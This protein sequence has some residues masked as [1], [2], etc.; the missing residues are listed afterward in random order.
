MLKVSIILPC[1]NVE[2]YI[3]VCLDSLRAQTLGDIE[4]ICVDDLST[5]NTVSIIRHYM[6]QDDRIHLIQHRENRGVG[7]ARNSGRG[8]ATGQYVSFIDPDDYVDTDFFEKLYSC[9]HKNN[10][11]VA[12]AGVKR[13]DATN[14]KVVIGELNEKIKID[15]MYLSGEHWSA[16][17]KREFLD[18]NNIYYP[19]DVPTGQDVVFLSHIALMQPRI[20]VVDDTYYHYI[21]NRP[22]SLDSR[23]LSHDKVLSRI[24]MLEY[25]VELLNRHEIQDSQARK[26]YLERHLLDHFMYTFNKNMDELDKRLMFDWLFTRKDFLTR[27]LLATKYTEYELDGLFSGNF[28]KFILPE[29]KTRLFFKER[30]PSGTRR[31]YICG[32]KVYS[33]KRKNSYRYLHGCPNKVVSVMGGLGNQMFQYAFGQLLDKN[34]AY[35]ISWFDAITPESAGTYRE[36][37]LGFFGIDLKTIPEQKTGVVS[38]IFRRARK[39]KMITEEPKNVYNASF[40]KEK[41]AIYKGYFQVA[42]YYDKIR[43]KLLQDFRPRNAINDKNSEIL[44]LIKSVNSI[45]LHVRRGD[46]LNLPEFGNACDLEYYNRAIEHI[47]KYTDAPH[48]FLFSDDTKWVQENIKIKHPYTVVDVNSGADSAWDIWLMKHC[49]H[50]IIANSSFSW[51][52]AWLNENPNKIVVAPKQWFA[53]GRRTDIVPT[54]WTRM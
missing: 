54:K 52:G 13:E 53:S 16:I 42:R 51:W 49:K 22:D 30:R 4:I 2:K 23:A 45:S 20:G 32:I 33:Y 50:N 35:D 47:A 36:L 7:A 3:G 17:Y 19:E 39:Y 8:V 48:F 46:Y 28:K 15:S 37:E 6:K 14:N 10:L 41:R 25:K 12:K 34:T 29:Y 26:I 40:F 1:Y 5:D 31:I 44:D 9:A 24:K 38:R 18:T 11:D 21:L 43:D 27:E